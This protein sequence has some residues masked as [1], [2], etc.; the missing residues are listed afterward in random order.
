MS[1]A[2]RFLLALA[3]LPIGVRAQG[4]VEWQ[5]QAVGTV[6]AQRFVGAGAGVGFRTASRVRIGGSA[7]VGD[8]VGTVA[9]RM[10][11]LA[12]FH[13]DPFERSGISP[14]AGGGLAMSATAKGT[15]EYLLV[16]VGVETSPA[17][18]LGWF[19]EAGVGGGL[20]FSGG[21]RLRRLRMAGRQ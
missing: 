2:A 6:L 12:S 4:T 16:L 19:V 15:D 8:Y 9:T 5:G 11:V 3:C 13:L 17:G 1:R 20:R 10:E 14:Y 21:I 7:S 18:R